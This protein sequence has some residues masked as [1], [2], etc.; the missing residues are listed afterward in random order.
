MKVK[1]LRQAIKDDLGI[2]DKVSIKLYLPGG[3][4]LQ[5]KEE[6]KTSELEEIKEGD[7]PDTSQIE[8]L[9]EEGAGDLIITDDKMTLRE[10]GIIDHLDKLEIEIVIKV[11]IDV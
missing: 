7:Q 10:A 9:L 1:Q 5:T 4:S 8:Y 2:K 6:K 3:A 11:S